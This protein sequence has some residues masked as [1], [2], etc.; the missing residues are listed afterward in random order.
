MLILALT[1]RFLSWVSAKILTGYV[2]LIVTEY[3]KKTLESKLKNE[4]TYKSTNTESI[5]F[6]R[7]KI[8]TNWKFSKESSVEKS[9][10]YIYFTS[11]SSSIFLLSLSFFSTLFF[12]PPV[13]FSSLL[14]SFSFACHTLIPSDITN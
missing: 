8:L 9:T 7:L 11:L 10:P 14:H 4:E 2:D 1:H 3:Y 13:I 12:S 5:G 6:P